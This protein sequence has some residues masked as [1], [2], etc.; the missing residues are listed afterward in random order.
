[1][2]LN[3][4]T[5]R[6]DAKHD[7]ILKDGKLIQTGQVGKGKSMVTVVFVQSFQGHCTQNHTI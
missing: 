7:F 6:W 2:P 5:G 1:M 4:D 3:K